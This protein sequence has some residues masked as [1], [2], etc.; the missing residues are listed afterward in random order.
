[1][2]QD[3]PDCPIPLVPLVTQPSHLRPPPHVSIKV[4][5]NLLGLL[6]VDHLVVLGVDCCGLQVLFPGQ[7][8]KLSTF[9]RLCNNQ[10][11]TLNPLLKRFQPFLFL[12]VKVF[13]G[14][15]GTLT[16]QFHTI[17]IGFGGLLPPYL[18]ICLQAG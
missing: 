11:P 14:C 12:T 8:C 3:V 15:L 2:V 9:V 1:M 17:I 7:D 10:F 4:V 13:I 5:L 18:Q 16:E 6:Y